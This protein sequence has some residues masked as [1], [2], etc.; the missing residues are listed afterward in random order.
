[1]AGVP[2]TVLENADCQNVYVHLTQ[3]L[4]G[5][6]R[7]QEAVTFLEQTGWPPL[8]ARFSAALRVLPAP[9]EE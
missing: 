7:V 3:L 2:D 9:A 5:S 8:T 4:M 6:E 1:M